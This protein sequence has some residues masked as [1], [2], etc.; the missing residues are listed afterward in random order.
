MANT[1]RSELDRE[2]EALVSKLEASVKDFETKDRKSLLRAAAKPVT[3]AVKAKINVSKYGHKRYKDG[4]VI[5]YNPGNLQN[6]M[7]TLSFRRS[8]DIFSGPKWGGGKAL[9][10]GGSGQPVDGYYYAM[11][12]GGKAFFRRAVLQPAAFE[13]EGEVLAYMKNKAVKRFKDR[14]KRNG[15]NTG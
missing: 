13:S 5:K 2:I 14:A 1:L 10:Y 9:E 7:K 15:L 11:A 4:K 3:K 8:P 12:Y 6:S